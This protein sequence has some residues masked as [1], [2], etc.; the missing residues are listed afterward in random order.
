MKGNPRPGILHHV[1]GIRSDVFALK[2]PR[3]ITFEGR[4]GCRK[5]AER[6]PEEA[7][8]L[9][10]YATKLQSSLTIGAERDIGIITRSLAG[11]WRRERRDLKPAL[12]ED[13]QRVLI[14]RIP[15]E[16]RGAVLF[17]QFRITPI[18]LHASQDL[19][20]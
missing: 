2:H 3:K 20:G 6:E 19:Q 13:S 10:A 9:V 12:L 18:Q 8:F 11:N 5:R 7:T 1:I 15:S 14:S 17:S 4:T 16:N